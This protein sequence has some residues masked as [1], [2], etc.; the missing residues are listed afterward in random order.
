MIASLVV[1]GLALGVGTWFLVW[2]SDLL[3][4]HRVQVNGVDGKLRQQVQSVANIETGQ[5]MIELPTAAIEQ[6]VEHI[7]WVRHATVTR[8]WPDAALVTV[9]ARQPLAR[10]AASGLAID[11]EGTIFEAPGEMAATLPMVIAS[12]TGRVE[13]MLALANMPADLV[14]RITSLT[15]STRDDLRFTLA[16]G[17]VVRWGNAGQSALKAE[18]LGALLKRK[19]LVYDVSAPFM[20]TTRG[21][22]RRSS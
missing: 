3:V 19:A 5:P 22:R 16:S 15:A 2:K 10:D 20:P 4:V 14:K 8:S 9:E 13:A 7:S 21:E 18:V 12:D 11:A 17:V 1:L 6:Q